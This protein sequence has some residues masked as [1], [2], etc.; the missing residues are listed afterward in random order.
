M[1]YLFLTTF[2]QMHKLLFI[3]LFFRYFLYK[4]IINIKFY[5]VRFLY[6]LDVN[7]I[8]CSNSERLY[9]S[10]III[11]IICNTYI[12]CILY[13]IPNCCNSFKMSFSY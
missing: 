9:C 2:I 8:S 10:T 6:I 5:I 13:R 4:S 1:K 7:F 3:N 11:I 12:F